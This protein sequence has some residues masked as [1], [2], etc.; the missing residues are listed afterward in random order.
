MKTF[1]VFPY[2]YRN[3]SGSLGERETVYMIIIIDVFQLLS[4]YHLRNRKHFPCF[5]TVIETRVEV[6][7]NVK[8]KWEYARSARM[9]SVSITISSS[10]KLSQVFL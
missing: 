8:L 6:W 10:S 9:A 1:S 3:T 2:S 7:E 4:Y 5:H